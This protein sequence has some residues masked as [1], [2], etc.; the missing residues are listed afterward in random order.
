MDSEVCPYMHT[1]MQT[2][3]TKKYHRK[4]NH[5]ST[6]KKKCSYYNIAR[7]ESGNTAYNKSS[8]HNPRLLNLLYICL[9]LFMIYHSCYI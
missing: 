8:S 6:R 2:I 4:I 1:H 5:F 3:V 7:L 9:L